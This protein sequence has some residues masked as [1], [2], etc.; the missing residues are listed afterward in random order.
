MT[1]LL[2]MDK[3]IND[4]DFRTALNFACEE[5]H[6]DVTKFLLEHD[7]KLDISGEEKK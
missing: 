4:F 2:K 1:L 7:A 3:S 6:S 5:G